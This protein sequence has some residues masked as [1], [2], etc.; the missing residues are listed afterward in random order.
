MEQKGLKIAISGKGGVG[1]TTLAS[2]FCYI[3][4][5]QGNKVL[6]V[7]ADPDANLGMALGFPT[8]LMEKSITIAQDR[9]LIKERT[10]A[11]PGTS[12]QWFSLNPTVEDIPEKYVIAH[13]GIKLLQMGAAPSG[14][15]GCYCPESTLLKAL[16]S[17]LVLDDRDAL[18]VDMEAGLEH[19]GR[20]TARGVDAFI[21]VVEPGQ[22]SFATARSV[23][24][25][26]K[27]LGVKKVYAVA[28][29]VGEV[30]PVVIQDALGDIPL[31]GLYPYTTEAVQADLQGQP[32]FDTCPDMVRRAEDILRRLS[33][34]MGDS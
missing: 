17:H 25:M 16:L 6:A 21:V 13:R 23:V 24:H 27:D 31:L 30:S 28:N 1:K 15:A 12:G 33:G 20:G 14:G 5:N 34:M 22:R 3:L 11:E 2:L 32:L 8:D 29:K 19:L 4:A 7:D 18:V 10:G 9:K 26:A